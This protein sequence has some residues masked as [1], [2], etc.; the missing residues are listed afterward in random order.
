MR[1]FSFLAIGLLMLFATGAVMAQTNDQM[2]E[3]SR[4][5]PEKVLQ[6][7]DTN[8]DG[9]IS[10]EEW[11]KK[12]EAFA[13]LDTNNDGFL[14][15]DELQRHMWRHNK[16]GRM[17]LRRMDQ[18]QDGQIS[19]EEWKGQPDIFNRIDADSN[20]LITREELKTYHHRKDEPK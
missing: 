8:S 1:H 19:R 6:Q 17:A 13:R 7:M 12:T 9:R 10:R 16:R 14:T 15:R 4:H 11:R 3:H 2:R 20:G 5:N 18:N